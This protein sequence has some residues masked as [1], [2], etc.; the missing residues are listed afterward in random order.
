M[1]RSQN[2]KE[3]IIYHMYLAKGLWTT[4]R[5]GS[6]PRL[7]IDR[8]PFG[9]LSYNIR[10]FAVAKINNILSDLHYVQQETLFSNFEHKWIC[11]PRGPGFAFDNA[12]GEEST[13]PQAIPMPFFTHNLQCMCIG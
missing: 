11:L 9:L 6:G 7:P 5:D 10:Y 13:E 1:L 3:N 2:G 4:R 12:E 8:M